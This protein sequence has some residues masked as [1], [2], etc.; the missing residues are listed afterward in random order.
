MGQGWE[1]SWSIRFVQSDHIPGPVLAGLENLLLVSL[2]TRFVVSVPR[3]PSRTTKVGRSLCV[4]RSKMKAK[5]SAFLFCGRW[6][7]ASFRQACPRGVQV[8]VWGG[9]QS[10]ESM[11][12]CT[13]SHVYSGR[14]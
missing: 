3:A 6:Q 9:C 1:N 14:A 4:E 13:A 11:Y 7:P 12:V 8:Q 2:P 5:C 10:P